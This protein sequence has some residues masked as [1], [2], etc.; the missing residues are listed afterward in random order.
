MG[1]LTGVRV[2]DMSQMISGP[3][4]ATW[5]ADQG[6]DVVKVEERAGDPARTL[7]PRKSDMSAV[8]LSVR[9]PDRPVEASTSAGRC[10]CIG[11]P[12]R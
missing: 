1:P 4:A 6:A 2:V 9:R 10:D 8:F 7:G 11:D 12:C 3:F 5:L